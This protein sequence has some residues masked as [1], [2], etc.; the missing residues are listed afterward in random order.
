[1]TPTEALHAYTRLGAYAGREEHLKGSLEPGRLADVA[2]LDRDLFT[3][4]PETIR[5]IEV[6]LT[7]VGG[8][9]MWRR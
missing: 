2:V 5:D 3:I 8:R 1:M 7:I 4:A 6:D 9:V